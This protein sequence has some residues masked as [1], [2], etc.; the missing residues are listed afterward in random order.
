MCVF[1]HLT[2]R[3]DR[4]MKKRYEYTVGSGVELAENKIECNVIS[5]IK[6][7][8]IK[9]KKPENQLNHEPL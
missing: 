6:T 3:L 5:K 7:S 4:S 2:T 1:T 9:T 8:K